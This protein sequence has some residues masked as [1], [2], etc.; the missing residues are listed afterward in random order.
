MTTHKKHRH[1]FT[2]GASG[3]VARRWWANNTTKPSEFLVEIKEC[4]C[5]E[6][7]ATVIKRYDF[8]NLVKGG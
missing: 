8:P 5:G 3:R 4:D 1:F 6:A 7:K 2:Y